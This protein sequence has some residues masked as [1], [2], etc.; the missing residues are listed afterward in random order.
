MR[1]CDDACPIKP[2]SYILLFRCD[3]VKVFP[4]LY[5]NMIFILLFSQTIKVETLRRHGVT[6]AAATDPSP[7]TSS[8]RR[9]WQALSDKSRAAWRQWGFRSSRGSAAP[10]RHG[11]V[12]IGR[13]LLVVQAAVGD[14]AKVRARSSSWW[15]RPPWA[16]WLQPLSWRWLLDQFRICMGLVWP[17]MSRSMKAVDLMYNILDGDLRSKIQVKTLSTAGC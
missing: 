5:L 16:P 9:R 7:S 8:P 11:A 1:P 14:M 6:L 3:L 10:R 12:E 15:C 4:L 13:P 2:C 17:V